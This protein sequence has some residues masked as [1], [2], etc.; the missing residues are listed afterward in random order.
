LIWI[1]DLGTI[2]EIVVACQQ[3]KPV[4]IC[5]KQG[6]KS[7]SDWAFP[8]L[9]YNLFFD[10]FDDIKKYLLHINNDEIIDDLKGKWQIFDFS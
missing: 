9:N 2:W 10:N 4:M 5:C 6:I 8:L 3:R 7:I 1:L